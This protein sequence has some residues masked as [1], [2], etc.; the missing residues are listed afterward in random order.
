MQW[1]QVWLNIEM[2]V[3]RIHFQNAA[4]K[5]QNQIEMSYYITQKRYYSKRNVLHGSVF[6]DTCLYFVLLR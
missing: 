2:C 4:F 3:K 1:W 6:I 5:N